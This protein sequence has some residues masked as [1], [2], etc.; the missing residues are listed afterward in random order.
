MKRELGE[1]FILFLGCGT[2]CF[3][4]RREKREKRRR[5]RRSIHKIE[6]KI[7]KLLAVSSDEKSTMRG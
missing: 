6:D 2:I 1:L 4:V 3:V 7:L 5:N